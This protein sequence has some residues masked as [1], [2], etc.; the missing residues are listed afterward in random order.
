MQEDLQKDWEKSYFM[1]DATFFFWWVFSRKDFLPEQDDYFWLRSVLPWSTYSGSKFFRYLAQHIDIDKRFDVWFYAD[2]GIDAKIPKTK[3]EIAKYSKEEQKII[4]QIN[5]KLWAN[6]CLN[7]EGVIFVKEALGI[8]ISEHIY[9]RPDPSAS[10][11]DVLLKEK[12]DN[13][14]KEFLAG[15][16]LVYRSNYFNFEKQKDLFIREVRE[17]KAFEN[18]TKNFIVSSDFHIHLSSE[19]KRQKLFIHT[20]YALEFLG[21]IEV[22]KIWFSGDSFSTNYYANILPNESFRELV[23]D[24]Y[25]KENPKTFIL[26]FDTKTD[27]LTLWKKKIQFSKSRKETDA[28]LLI[29]SLIKQKNTDYLHEDEILEEWGYRTPEEQKKTAKNK[30]YNA[31]LKIQTTMKLEADIDDFIEYNTTKVRINPKYRSL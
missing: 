2:S 10:H 12:L 29:R 1:D 9:F 16:L 11:N 13:Y 4:W 24:E 28:V 26:W 17:M 30:V 22:L 27:T 5:K 20:L 25:R 31:C 6:K 7:A 23:Y 15:E 8:S 18:Y 3:E 21:F 19:E 14:I